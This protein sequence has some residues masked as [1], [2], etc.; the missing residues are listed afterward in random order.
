MSK[1]NAEMILKEMRAL[2]TKIRYF[3]NQNYLKI[4]FKSYLLSIS[5][6]MGCFANL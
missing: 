6:S 4:E 2:A 3:H 5:S 1:T